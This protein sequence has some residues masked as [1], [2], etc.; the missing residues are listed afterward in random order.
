MPE[1]P[2]EGLLSHV[3]GGGTIQPADLERPNQT[4]VVRFVDGD[5]VVGRL[6]LAVLFDEDSLSHGKAPVRCRR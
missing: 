6:A 4:R 3:L 2:G 1:R 5:K